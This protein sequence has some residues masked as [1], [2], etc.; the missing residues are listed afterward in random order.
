MTDSVNDHPY[1]VGFLDIEDGRTISAVGA[2]EE[3]LE[4]LEVLEEL[5]G[6]E[7]DPDNREL[8]E[9]AY[10]PRYEEFER[11]LEQHSDELSDNLSELDYE[12][13]V[14]EAL[15]YNPMTLQRFFPEELQE[16]IKQRKA[17]LPPIR[18]QSPEGANDRLQ[19]WSEAAK[20]EAA[21]YAEET[22]EELVDYNEVK[23]NTVVV[24]AEE[25]EDLAIVAGNFIRE[26]FDQEH[27]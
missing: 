11:Q 15:E 1:V 14:G 7:P 20:E 27:F 12:E 26:Q 8:A 4:V 6:T 24:Y 13:L 3:D 19:E 21:K 18:P 10:G 2:E 23:R 16:R 9:V 5:E 25:Y 22:G 17:G